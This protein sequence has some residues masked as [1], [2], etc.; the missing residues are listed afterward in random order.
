MSNR[1]ALYILQLCLITIGS[2]FTSNTNLFAK[3]HEKFK[4]ALLLPA[5][6]T[7]GGQNIP[8]INSIFT[9]YEKGVKSVNLD[10]EIR[11]SYESLRTVEKT[12]SLKDDWLFFC[13]P[14][15]L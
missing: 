2:A 3:G 14:E 1:I 6:I 8:A 4:V 11:R 10:A 15:I 5:S 9:A 7:D 13:C 12:F